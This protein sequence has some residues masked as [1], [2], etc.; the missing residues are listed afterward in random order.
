MQLHIKYLEQNGHSILLLLLSS[1]YNIITSQSAYILFYNVHI[2]KVSIVLRL[3][4]CA[5]KN[6]KHFYAL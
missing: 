5:Y 4:L 1:L 6:E 3:L 2:L